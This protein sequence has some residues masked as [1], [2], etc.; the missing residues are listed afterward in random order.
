MELKDHISY[1][2]EFIEINIISGK[3][4]N[5]YDNKFVPINTKLENPKETI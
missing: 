5:P 1:M 4:T 2:E 3:T